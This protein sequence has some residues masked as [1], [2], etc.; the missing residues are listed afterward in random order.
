MIRGLY[1]VATGRGKITRLGGYVRL[2]DQK[3]SGTHGGTNSASAWNTRT[4][5]TKT[6]DTLAEC[7]LVSNQFLLLPGTYLAKAKSV[8]VNS[9]RSRIRIQNVTDGVTLALGLNCY[10]FAGGDGIPAYLTDVF[11]VA[12]SKWLELQYRTEGSDGQPYGLGF[13]SSF[14]EVEVYSEVELWRLT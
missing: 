4:L 13:A 14:G 6:D 5:N 10:V 2:Q 8:L 3:A 9:G 1:G 7:L 12:G 11:T